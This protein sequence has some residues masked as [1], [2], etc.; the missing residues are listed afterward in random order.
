M[1]EEERSNRVIKKIGLKVRNPPGEKREAFV[2]IGKIGYTGS[3]GKK[4]K[5]KDTIICLGGRPSFL[6]YH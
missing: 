3:V 4:E 2:N 6:L 1:S 5:R